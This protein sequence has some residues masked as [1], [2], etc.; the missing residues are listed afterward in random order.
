MTTT[1][2]AGN[3]SAGGEKSL[4]KAHVPYGDD[5]KGHYTLATK[6]CFDVIENATA[7]C[8]EALRGVPLPPASQ[9]LQISDY[10]T[11]DGGTSMPL[12]SAL[13]REVRAREPA[14]EVLV[15][16]EDQPNNDFKS[17]F[18]YVQGLQSVGRAG[19]S[20][21]YLKEFPEGVFVQCSGTSFHE[22]CF[23]TGSVHFGMS[24]TAMHW[25]SEK[26][27]DITTGVHMTQAQGQEKDA[28]ARVAAKDWSHLLQ[29]RSKELAVG[30]K[31]VI[32]NFC[33]DAQGYYL[34]KTDKPVCMYDTFDKHWRAMR[35]E[36]K[37]TQ[38]E[39]AGGTLLNYYRNDQEM[40]H[41]FQEGEA[42]HASGLRLVSCESKITRC[43]YNE[44][45]RR[46]VAAGEPVDDRAAAKGIIGTMRTWS[47]SSFLTALSGS[48]PAAER[49]ALVDEL[50]QR[51]E[52]E[53]AQDPA[54]HHMDYAHHYILVEKVAA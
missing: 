18:F 31:M 39:Y 50:Y 45:Y 34:G 8:V 24:F 7:L 29:L 20:Q 41:P 10:G 5:G 26:P 1:T 40:K 37:I 30:G 47:N 23:P 43:P 27:C 9:P 14:R 36:G 16:Y 25:L 32:V 52:D 4:G 13:I 33:V 2:T 21:T 6:G 51:Y 19:Y 35:D 28:F 46:A 22:Q 48:R 15:A 12:I 11:A 17:L 42:V 44:E 53:I 54:S 49:Q 38:E 3:A